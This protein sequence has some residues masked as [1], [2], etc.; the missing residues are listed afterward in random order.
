MAWVSHMLSRSSPRNPASAPGLVVRRQATPVAIA[1][2]GLQTM[3]QGTIPRTVMRISW[4]RIKALVFVLRQCLAAFL[5]RGIGSVVPC[6]TLYIEGVV[7][8]SQFTTLKQWSSLLAE[9]FHLESKLC[10]STSSFELFNFDLMIGNAERM[11]FR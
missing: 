3:D 11:V 5:W 2:A 10:Q 8:I 7:A 1:N 4:R 9:R 6:L